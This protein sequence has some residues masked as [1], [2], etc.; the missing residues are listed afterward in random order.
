[1]LQI[2]SRVVFTQE[3]DLFTYIFCCCMH[4][5]GCLHAYNCVSA[6]FY[7]TFPFDT[8]LPLLVRIH[9]WYYST[10]PGPDS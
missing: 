8:T 4:L 5:S 10:L 2:I 1:M 3:K 6:C 7:V 9:Q